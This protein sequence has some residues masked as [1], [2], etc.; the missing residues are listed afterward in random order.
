MF[1]DLTLGLTAMAMVILCLTY[2]YAA[3]YQTGANVLLKTSARGRE[4]TFLCKFGIGVI[5]VTIIFALTYTPYFYNVI[6]AYGTRGINA[7]ACSIESL[8]NFDVSIKG[9]LILIIA[10][11]YLALLCAMLIIYFLSAKLKSVISTFL[12]ATA[13]LILPILLALLGIGFFD[14][15]LLN[16]IL[17]GNI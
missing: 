1:K 15:V 8:S 7:P 4:D 5:I 12:A 3:E 13:V 10:G 14:Y 9:Y 6:S 2:V 11:R 17:I 16:P